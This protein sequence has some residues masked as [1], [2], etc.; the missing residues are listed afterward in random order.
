MNVKNPAK[1]PCAARPTAA[2]A[3]LATLV[4]VAAL[5]VVAAP[6]AGADD[7]NLTQRVHIEQSKSAFELKLEQIEESTRQRAAEQRREGAARPLEPVDLGD[8]DESLR[9]T[10]IDPIE[11]PPASL[12]ES[13]AGLETEQA[14]DRRQREILDQRQQR[15]A[16]RID[17]P[18]VRSNAIG[19]YARERSDSVRFRSES[20]QQTLQRKLRP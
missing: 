1:A 18:V 12:S 8:A 7:G 14:Y 16:L 5:A 11:S 17:S 15:R 6:R 3:T 19:S 13:A 10:P 4:S 9:L 2:A 20:R